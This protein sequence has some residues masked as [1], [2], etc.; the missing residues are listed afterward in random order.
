MS[1]Y[2]TCRLCGNEATVGDY[3]EVCVPHYKTEYKTTQVVTKGWQ[4]PACDT[5]YAPHIQCC[6]C[7]HRPHNPVSESTFEHIVRPETYTQ[8][9]ETSPAFDLICDNW[10][11]AQPSPKGL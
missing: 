10:G 5:V 4:C 7:Q 1:I 6:F 9:R 8:Y 3:C 11:P 2:M